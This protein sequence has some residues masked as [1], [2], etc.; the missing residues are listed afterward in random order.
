L[1]L[2][3]WKIGLLFVVCFID[4]TV[5]MKIGYIVAFVLYLRI[6]FIDENKFSTLLKLIVGIGIV[7]FFLSLKY[8]RKKKL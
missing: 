1:I 7:L 8:F 3:L 2:G 4:H 5:L 6:I